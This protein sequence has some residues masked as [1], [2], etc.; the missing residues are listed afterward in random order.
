[1]A[2]GF[3]FYDLNPNKTVQKII[4]VQYDWGDDEVSDEAKDFIGKLLVKDPRQRMTTDQ[5]LEHSWIIKSST[6]SKKNRNGFV[7]KLQKLKQKFK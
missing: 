1:M 3:P 2:G 7:D 6:L 4:S 5:A